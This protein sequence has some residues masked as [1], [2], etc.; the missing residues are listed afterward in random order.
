MWTAHSVGHSLGPFW[1]T[2]AASLRQQYSSRLSSEHSNADEK[3]LHFKLVQK[4]AMLL[5]ALTALPANKGVW[6]ID[7]MQNGHSKRGCDVS[8][9]AVQ[10][11]TQAVSLPQSHSSLALW[12]YGNDLHDVPRAY[13]K[14]RGFRTNT[15]GG[16][17]G[18]CLR[19][20][21]PSSGA[22]HAGRAKNSALHSR[23]NTAQLRSSA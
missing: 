2:H 12:K 20:A 17:H 22:Q 15:V 4:C 10:G 16:L 1:L 21:W 11:Y 7:R 6:G 5:G 14:V 18:K 19:A 3:V 13:R 9:S 8:V 23:A